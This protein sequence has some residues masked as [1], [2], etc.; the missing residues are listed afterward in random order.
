MRR[1][2]QIE[3]TARYLWHAPSSTPRSWRDAS[4]KVVPNCTCIAALACQFQKEENVLVQK[5]NIYSSTASRIMTNSSFVLKQHYRPLKHRTRNKRWRSN[6]TNQIYRQHLG[7]KLPS[8]KKRIQPQHMPMRSS[9]RRFSATRKSIIQTDIVYLG[10]SSQIILLTA[11]HGTW[12]VL[13]QIIHCHAL[14]F[15]PI[16][17]GE[18]QY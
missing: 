2:H 10:G 1:S 18:L 6:S 17:T 15:D 8:M 12:N 14:H 4:D 13:L 16:Q 7:Q 9:F 3:C 5:E 11:R